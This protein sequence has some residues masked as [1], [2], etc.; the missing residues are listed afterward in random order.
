MTFHTGLVIIDGKSLWP[1][2][3]LSLYL[4]LTP[5]LVS[6]TN[7]AQLFF[8]RDIS[9]VFVAI[10]V[11]MNGKMRDIAMAGDTRNRIFGHASQRRTFFDFFFSTLHMTGNTF[12]LQLQMSAVVH[13][14]SHSSLQ[15]LRIHH[16]ACGLHPRFVD[17][18]QIF[19][20]QLA[21][22]E[23]RGGMALHAIL[24][25]NRC[26]HRIRA[27]R[28]G[29]RIAWRPREVQKLYGKV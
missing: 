29:I 27:L 2:L 5:V 20:A 8:R 6:V 9:R 19:C 12:L 24:I 11:Q 28:I 15:H 25:R 4:P 7:A 3:T 14:Q 17:L 1:A 22:A 23:R 13:C 16:L 10:V 18:R 21:Q 26:L